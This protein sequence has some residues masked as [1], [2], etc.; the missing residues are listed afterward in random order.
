MLKLNIDI[1]N[2]WLNYFRK[3]LN[4]STKF[5][6]ILK[7]SISLKKTVLEIYNSKKNLLYKELSS[8][9]WDFNKELKV[10]IYPWY[11]YLGAIN[12]ELWII[13]LWQP[14][15]CKHYYL[16]LI[17]HETSHFLLKK[18][19]LNRFIEEIICFSVEKKIIES[20]DWIDTK[21]FIYYENIDLFHKKALYYTHKF[22]N[23]FL[24]TDLF[25]FIEF[26]N[27]EIPSEFKDIE[28]STSLT[29]YL[30]ENE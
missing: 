22:Y 25:W 1:N 18:Y 29:N 21:D 7:D 12:T 2:D 3:K 13:V 26:L 11:F 17:S 8:I 23:D 20:F 16:W 14:S 4:K 10:E 28:I 6:I 9:F 5:K 24:D 15:F 19:N 27:K 30:K